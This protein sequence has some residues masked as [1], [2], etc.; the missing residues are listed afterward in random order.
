MKRLFVVITLAVSAIVL[1][2]C[3]PSRY[4]VTERPVAPVYARPAAPRPHYVWV[5]GDWRWHSG[6]Y[7]YSNGY[8]TKPRGKKIYVTGDWVHT[9]KG[10]YWK[11]GYWK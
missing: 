4:T 7:V 1:D 11:K 2:G 6:K 10:Y 5:D 8:W 9:N 3:G